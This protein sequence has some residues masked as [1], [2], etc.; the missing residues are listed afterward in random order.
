MDD[1]ARMMGSSEEEEEEGGEGAGWGRGEEQ[2]E[3]KQGRSDDDD[4]DDYDDDDDDDEDG[5]EAWGEVEEAMQ[6]EQACPVDQTGDQTVD[7]GPLD[8]NGL[9]AELER[10]RAENRWDC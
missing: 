10:L 2:E 5:D 7:Q 1:V 9:L 6:D 3:T 8:Q 4:D